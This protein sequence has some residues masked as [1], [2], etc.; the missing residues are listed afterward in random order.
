MCIVSSSEKLSCS[1]SVMSIIPIMPEA[2]SKDHKDWSFSNGNLAYPH[3]WPLVFEGLD[4]KRPMHYEGI[5]P[6]ISDLLA[7][8]SSWTAGS[9]LAVCRWRL[10]IS[11]QHQS[12]F[13]MRF[14]WNGAPHRFCIIKNMLPS[15]PKKNKQLDNLHVFCSFLELANQTRS[16]S[17]AKTN[18]PLPSL[19]KASQQFLRSTTTSTPTK[20]EAPLTIRRIFR[21]VEGIVSREHDLNLTAWHFG[22]FNVDKDDT[23]VAMH[24]HGCSD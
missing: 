7:Y 12:F 23:S 2:S 10:G 5:A 11:L 19:D 16:V 14:L 15:T 24:L 13:N 4:P 20:F 6:R 22:T 3:E 1:N 8:I 21:A 9:R 17:L 18:G